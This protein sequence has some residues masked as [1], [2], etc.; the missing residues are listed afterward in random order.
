ML[1]SA[2]KADPGLMDESQSRA[3]SVW[4]KGK[5]S[6]SVQGLPHLTPCLHINQRQTP[7]SPATFS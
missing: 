6:K 3:E 7:V 5:P 1:A 4:A 2:S